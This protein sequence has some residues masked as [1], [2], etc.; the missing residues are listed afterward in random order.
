MS[1]A[2]GALVTAT[3]RVWILSHIR[4]ICKE[5]QM[6]KLFV[7]IDTDSIHA[8]ASY[9]KAD[10][11]E[12]GGFKLEAECEAVKY[13][14]PKTYVDIERVRDGYVELN[15]IEIHTK[16]VNVMSVRNDFQSVDL[17]LDYIDKR[18]NY[19]E[20]FNV[21]CAMN[22]HGGKVLCP[23]AKYLA[24][25]EQAPDETFVVT[26]GYNENMIMER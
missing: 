16:G 23:T 1:V 4:E 18:F 26:Y 24:R 9:D 25:Y 17:T 22:V 21:L 13:I 8:F 11:Y 15:D 20:K 14:A 3:A 12:L 2:L 6:S 7:Y 19:G 5:E 10:A